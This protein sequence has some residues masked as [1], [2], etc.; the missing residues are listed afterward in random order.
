MMKGL[1][2]ESNGGCLI[3]NNKKGKKIEV[4]KKMMIL[5]SAIMMAA[6]A[7]A[8]RV[9]TASFDEVRV[10]VPARVRIIAG[11]TYSVNVAAQNE[12]VASA[13][14]YEVKD[15]VLKINSRDID[16]LM[17]SEEPL[18][19]TIVAPKDLK[20]TIGRN[21]EAVNVLKSFDEKKDVAAN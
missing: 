5:A 20:L 15:G 6:T 7:N 18:H 13:V 17:Q 14:R 4:M 1:E 8:K 11:E 19:I 10:N 16:E 21:M 12:M 3:K 9:E 2:R